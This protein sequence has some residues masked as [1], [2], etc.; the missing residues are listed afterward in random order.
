[1]QSLWML[2]AA[3]LFSIMGICVKLAS[4]QYT[5]AEIVTTRG[6]IGMLSIFIL[7]RIKGGTLKTP[8]LRQHAQRGLIGTLSLW[9]GFYALSVLPIATATTLTYTSS[10]WLAVIIFISTWWRGEKRFEWPLAITILISFIGVALL[11]RP[12]PSINAQQTIGGIIALIAGFVA[13]LAYMQVRQL[14]K[15]GEPEY[16][17]VF[18]F[19]A[20]CAI[21]GTL[22]N[23]IYA[24]GAIPLWHAHSAQGISLLIILGVTATL[25]Q[26]A[27]T[28]AYR[29]GNALLTANLQYSGIVFS[30][31]WGILIFQDQLDWLGW[32]GIAVILIGGLLAT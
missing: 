14:G 30:S 6:I 2:I 10:I 32:I 5:V 13:A 27:L 3:L 25:A 22:G 28:R 26:M 8:L 29:L 1:M 15:L 19:S 16:R 17:V 24:A 21:A 20:V 23:L 31:I 7:I 4:D 12:S 11:L 18:Y 9:L